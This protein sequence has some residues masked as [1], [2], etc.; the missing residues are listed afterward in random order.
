M[1]PSL[2]VKKGQF[3]RHKSVADVL[4]QS[5]SRL[6]RTQSNRTR[7]GSLDIGHLVNEEA[8][9]SYYDIHRL[10]NE[11][12]G[13]A[14]L[15]EEYTEYIL[16]QNQSQSSRSCA[17][18]WCVYAIHLTLGSMEIV[19]TSSRDSID[20]LWTYAPLLCLIP[21]V[22]FA[23]AKRKTSAQAHALLVLVIAH[24]FALS[25]LLGPGLF[26][27]RMPWKQIF[28]PFWETVFASSSLST[29]AS[30]S[31]LERLKLVLAQSWEFY[32]TSQDEPKFLGPEVQDLNSVEDLMG[33]YVNAIMLPV[34]EANAHLL[35]PIL[36]LVLTPVLFK[37]S[38]GQ[39][40]FL[41]MNV[42]ILSLVMLLTQFPLSTD[43][44]LILNEF[45]LVLVLLGLS[46]TLVGAHW[47][48]DRHQRLMYIYQQRIENQERAASDQKQ[49]FQ[50]ENSSLRALLDEH[51]ELRGEDSTGGPGMNLDSP[52]VKILSDLKLVG[53]SIQNQQ[54]KDRLQSVLALLSSSNNEEG[55]QSL[56]I[57]DLDKALSQRFE[58]ADMDSD[59]KGWATTQLTAGSYR[60]LPKT[61]SRVVKPDNP[62]SSQKVTTKQNVEKSN[63]A[64][65][66]RRRQ[67]TLS[68]LP[69]VRPPQAETLQHI[70][71]LMEEDGW[72]VNTMQI[73]ELCEHRPVTYV[74][75]II[76]EMHNLFEASQV[77]PVVLN[78]FLWYIDEGYLPN[79][80]HNR[81]HAADV[82]VCARYIVA[83]MDD[84]YVQNLLT[85]LEFFALVIAAAIHDFRH[86]GRNNSF[87]IHSHNHLALKYSD[88]S[89]LERMHLAE[90]FYLTEKP[91]F[92]I[93]AGMKPEAYH[94]VRK[95]MIEIVL[96]TDLMNHLQ[97]VGRL[98]TAI[99][100]SNQGQLLEDPITIMKIVIK[101]ADLGHCAKKPK[102][103]GLWTERIV[104]EFFQQG[105][106]EARLNMIISPFMNRSLENSAQNQIGFFDFILLPF[107][108]IVNDIIVTN[109]YHEIRNQLHEN[110]AKWCQAHELGMTSVTEITGQFFQE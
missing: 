17:A 25:T 6:L 18:L 69:N 88:A 24:A 97:F 100:G 30:E 21:V 90:A 36:V 84:G 64:R 61:K 102:L 39:Y 41:S 27:L 47:Q 85:P 45:W 108:N 14:D 83:G 48:L 10:C 46:T 79:A 109:G 2:L 8:M 98:E 20:R 29:N 56:F 34:V 13:D 66:S 53:S 81:N 43:P 26:P 15:E 106:E 105:D 11:F 73:N 71:T 92:N 63:N 5:S 37:L 31:E 35:S 33:H 94:Q 77:D 96:C 19:P 59:T 42:N 55:M 58:K 65:L 78:N 67:S 50:R 110:Y 95:A 87:L 12:L 54:M 23:Q 16:E 103:H 49:Q 3:K 60:R 91:E 22:L 104:E 86:P 9:V 52:I 99:L 28:G 7:T 80:Y 68:L 40:A 4:N 107:F 89:V 74:T 76:F 93:F 57:P 72:S 51:A 62:S 70:M 101:S 82:V 44:Y 75:W 38:I 32:S 1:R